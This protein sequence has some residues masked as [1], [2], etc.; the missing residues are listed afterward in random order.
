[1]SA[2]DPSANI[3]PPKDGEDLTSR[4]EPIQAHH[5]KDKHWVLDDNTGLPG[6][7]SDLKMS[8]TGKHGH[9]KFTYKLKMP[10][11]GRSSSPMHPG[12]DHLLRPVM[13]KKEYEVM[14]YQEDILSILDDDEERTL[15]LVRD[16]PLGQ[17]IVA[18]IQEAED[19]GKVVVVATQEGPQK[20]KE[21][22]HLIEMVVGYKMAD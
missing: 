10:F 3:L 18:A 22:V 21:K 20:L 5:L 1:M 12:G 4:L 7:V 17:K 11:S 19:S 8:K 2:L 6:E 16:S 15:K 9:A 13:A 14:D